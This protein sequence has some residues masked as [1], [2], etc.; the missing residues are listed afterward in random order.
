VAGRPLTGLRVGRPT[1]DDYLEMIGV[2]DDWW[3][4]RQVPGLLGRLWF[5]HFSGTSGLARTSSGELAGFLVAFQSPDQPGVMVLV[6]VAVNPNLRRRGVG[7]MVHDQ[8]LADARRLGC[9]ELEASVFPGDP[10]AIAYLG[11][12][13]YHVSDGPGTSRLYGVPAFPDHEWGRE[14]RAVFT[15]RLADT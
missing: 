3:G 7:R 10:A 14:D 8:L 1:P 12:L 13:G 9:Q 15:L 11:S 4:R 5:E 2:Q 6:A